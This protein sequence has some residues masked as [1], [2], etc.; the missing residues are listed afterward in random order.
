MRTIRY[1]IGTLLIAL[2]SIG[3]FVTPAIAA[4]TLS[5][6]QV[7]EI[8]SYLLSAGTYEVFNTELDRIQSEY[9][10]DGIE[11]QQINSQIDQLQA[12]GWIEEQLEYNLEVI[13]DWLKGDTVAP[14][15]YIDTTQDTDAIQYALALFIFDNID[16]EAFCQDNSSQEGSQAYTDYCVNGENPS[17]EEIITF[18]EDLLPPEASTEGITIPL[19]EVGLD[20]AAVGGIG[21]LYSLFNIIPI[22]LAFATFVLAFLLILVWPNHRNALIINGWVFAITGTV[23]LVLTS[24]FLLS[25]SILSPVSIASQADSNLTVLFESAF[26]LLNSM[27][28]T[29]FQRGLMLYAA[30]VGLGVLAFLIASL[31]KLI[32]SS[33]KSSPSSQSDTSEVTQTDTIQP[34][35]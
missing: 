23:G 21:R 30:S 26:T 32:N 16:R 13:D 34:Q 17:V 12:S 6:Q 11:G 28:Q 15:L 35:N 4:V 2:I 7:S 3:A 25:T 8:Q 14:D 33:Q 5:I 10:S 31:I 18:T 1:I 29:M 20:I 27:L 24:I 22:T 9:E 19:S